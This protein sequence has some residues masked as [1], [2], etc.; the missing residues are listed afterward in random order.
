MT[1]TDGMA[2]C[3]QRPEQP[4]NPTGGVSTSPARDTLLWRAGQL[5]GGLL[6]LGIG[7]ST[8][9]LHLTLGNAEL[10]RLWD[11][12]PPPAF[13]SAVILTL[14]GIGLLGL[15]TGRW[16]LSRAAIALLLAHGGVLLA[17][18]AT[19][20]NPWLAMR[21]CEV[22]CF[23][24]QLL[25][26]V[27]F[28]VMIAWS[29]YLNARPQPGERRLLMAMI[30]GLFFL[31]GTGII[32]AVQYMSGTPPLAASVACLIGCVI[33]GLATTLAAVRH[34]LE[35][36]VPRFV[37]PTA[38]AA[39][40][41][42]TTIALWAALD[43]DQTQRIRLETQAEAAQLQR[44]VQQDLDAQ[45]AEIRQ[46]AQQWPTRADR[47]R[48]NTVSRYVGL[49]PM[50]LGVAVVTAGPS[51]EWIEWSRSGLPPPNAWLQQHDELVAALREGNP[52]MVRLPR[53]D[54]Q[55]SRVIAVVFPFPPAS[56][57]SFRGGLLAIYDLDLWIDQMLSR[58]LTLGFAVKLHD[59][60]EEIV[61]RLSRSAPP[62]PQW[63]QTL[64]I[65]LFGQR[66]QLTVWPGPEVLDRQSLILPRLT[67]LVGLLGTLLTSLTVQLALT[68]ARR[69]RQLE[70]E[71]CE[72]RAAETALRQS[73]EQYRTLVEHLGQGVFLLDQDG[74]Y[75]TANSRYCQLVGRPLEQLVGRKKIEFVPPQWARRYPAIHQAVVERG[76][77]VEDEETWDTPLGR[78]QIR[79]TLMPVRGVDGELRG[80]LG[81]CWDVT[82]LRQLE[83]QVLQASK[84]DAIGQLAGG[85]AHDFN[86]LLTVILGNLDLLGNIV[87]PDSPHY[88]ARQAAQNAAQRAADLTRRLLAFARNHQ[89]DWQPVDINAVAADVITLL[90]R[91]IDPRI[92]LRLQRAEPLWSVR[93]DATQLHQVLMNLCLNARDAIT[94]PGT[95]T[96]ETSCIAAIT[97]PPTANG[98]PAAGDYVRLS[99]I[100][101]GCGMSPE[102]QARMF[103]PFFTTKE[104]GKGTGLGLSMVFA[105]V[106]QHKG[107]IECHSEVGKGTRFD[108]Y[109]PRYQPTN[110][111]VLARPATQQPTPAASAMP[112]VA[113]TPET[114]ATS[115]APATPARRRTI[116]LVDDEE[117]I[118]QLARL[119]LQS[120]GYQVIEA[121]DGQQAL[122]L[123][124]QHRQQIDLVILD[125]TMP[126]LSGQEVFQR[127]LA[128]DPAVPVIFASGYAVEQLDDSE[129][130]KMAGFIRK[131]YRPSE[132][133]E[134]VAAVWDKLDRPSE[135]PFSPFESVGV[136]STVYSL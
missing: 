19:G 43:H 60:V 8:A 120:H 115:D 48:R 99:V 93:A 69:A 116:L 136:D 118:R 100:D 3:S 112:A 79:R 63:Q 104:P 70:R 15:G 1:L 16:S 105:I 14:W 17:G 73:E 65:H 86:N 22:G 51:L 133:L 85:I 92:E 74:R 84:M 78:L 106:E 68:N 109:L 102:V 131:P 66:W 54:W 11:R 52:R 36:G 132:L 6:L 91:T 26:L 62:R 111:Q 12:L 89:L 108:I 38:T 72:R 55:G 44:S 114:A 18:A 35:A 31:L 5:L 41:I 103:E 42:T 32:L 50:C 125:L 28:S 59:G 10:L 127:L 45:F 67:V 134:V 128:I 82:Q 129:R 95:I 4:P 30:V 135:N 40:G 97:P 94:P 27:L 77:V 81:I 47:E 130:E 110:S 58:H 46:W 83:N 23:S 29:L 107:W 64:P 90:R 2:A 88:P 76:E 71:N 117:L 122:D 34:S 49:T 20:C 124:R 119:T 61:P 80:V 126:Q 33:G 53:S 75:I 113:A 101:T 98:K 7:A 21:C 37:L 123:F 25:P 96:I 87:P 57:Q 9:A 13:E 56:G 39:L 121:E 24:L